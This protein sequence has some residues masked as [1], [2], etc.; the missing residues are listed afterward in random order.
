[1]DV[2]I[3]QKEIENYV[4]D[5]Y[6]MKTNEDVWYDSSQIYIQDP[7]YR[8]HQDS[9]TEEV[10]YSSDSNSESNWRND[11]PDTDSSS[12]SDL[13]YAD[14]VHSEESSHSSLQTLSDSSFTVSSSSLIE[15][16]NS[17]DIEKEK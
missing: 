2:Y 14:G 9:D 15:S 11:Y 8:E 12:E 16:S 3:F 4:Y 10:E 17:S 6:Y 5:L 7:K 13:L 1:M